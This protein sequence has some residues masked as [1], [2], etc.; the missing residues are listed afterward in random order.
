MDEEIDLSTGDF[1]YQSD[2]ELFL[3]V[4]DEDEDSYRFSVHGWR[5]IGKNRLEEYLSHQNGKL[6]SKEDIESFVTEK[7][8]DKERE[9][10]EKLKK[11]FDSYDNI[12]LGDD[13]P[14][15]EFSLD[16]S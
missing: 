6:H 10:Y 5:T 1:V 8:D 13:G 11:M 14:H 3:V 9:N 16:D 4:V 7:G 2:Q 12:E 15:K